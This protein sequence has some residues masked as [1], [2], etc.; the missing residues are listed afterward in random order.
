MRL[1]S[2]LA[3]A[4]VEQGRCFI[5]LWSTTVSVSTAEGVNPLPSHPWPY[6][7][8]FTTFKEFG[9]I[10]AY[11]YAYAYAVAAA[12]RVRRGGHLRFTS[13]RASQLEPAGPSSLARPLEFICFAC[14]ALRRSRCGRVQNRVTQG[15]AVHEHHVPH[16]RRGPFSSH[17]A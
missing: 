14:P 7:N 13:S 2:I 4:A 8:S 11:A 3:G 16:E 1:S 12:K 6:R 5:R 17:F 15:D 9:G 10:G